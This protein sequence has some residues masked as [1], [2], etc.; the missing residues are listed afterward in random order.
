MP[1][2]LP[3]LPLPWQSPAAP[4]ISPC[5]GNL[6]VSW[7]SPGVLAISRCPGNLAVSW[8]SRGVLAISRCPGNLRSWQHC[9]MDAPRTART[10]WT[11]F[12]PLHAVTYFADECIEEYARRRPEGLLDGL[13][14]AVDRRPMGAV[15]PGRRRRHLL[16]L[17]PRPG[18]PGP[19]RRLV[20]R[21]P[22]T[23]CSTRGW[24]GSTGPC[25]ASSAPTGAPCA[26]IGA[27]RTPPRLARAAVDGL[28]IDGRPLAAAN[29]ALTWPD[30][31]HLALWHAATVLREHRGDGHVAALVAAGLDGRQALVTMAAT[32]AVPREMLQ[33]ARGWDDD[34]W[35]RVGRCLVERGWL[36]DDGTPDRR[37]GPATVRR[38]R[39]SPIVWPPQPWERLGD[40]GTESLRVVLTAAHP[41]AC[42]RRRRWRCPCPTPSACP[43]PE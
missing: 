22:R 9:P 32:G 17:Q 25:G 23:G 7:Q 16:Q 13:L 38:S 43:P 21:R 20:I 36:N 11:L 28:T 37:R 18:G 29:V 19:P 33:A 12:E 14:R 30:E 41:R 42:H 6:A 24:P 15:G 10:M 40:D 5:P 4:A 35:E 31:P 3:G 8:Q 1:R 39:T 26:D 2:S 27:G 34:A